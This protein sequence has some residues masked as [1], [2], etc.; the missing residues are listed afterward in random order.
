MKDGAWGLSTGL[1]YNPGTYAKTDEIIALAKV[2]AQARRLLRQPHPRRGRRRCSTPSRRPSRSAARPA[3]ASTSRTSRRRARR[4]GASR[5]TRSPSSR[6]PARRAQAVTA[7]QYPYIASSTSLAATVVPPKYREGTQKD[8]VAR[9]DDPKHGP[10]MQGRHREG[11]R[12][13]RRRQDASRSPATRRSRS[14][15]ARTSPP[16]PRPRRRS[17]STSCWRSSA[18]AGRRSSTSA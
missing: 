16:S 7:D 15:R 17:R 8:F 2:A 1:I 18:T 6:R 9:L 13:P 10:Q 4:R 11:A 12:R 3:A 5:P 14:G